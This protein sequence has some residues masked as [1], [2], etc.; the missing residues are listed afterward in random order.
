MSLFILEQDFKLSANQQTIGGIFNE[1]EPWFIADLRHFHQGDLLFVARDEARLNALYDSLSYLC[2]ESLILKFPA[3]DCLPYD[4]VS[5]RRDIVATRVATLAQLSQAQAQPHRLRVILTTPSALVQ[6]VPPKAA[7]NFGTLDLKVGDTIQLQS[8]IASLSEHGYL[9][10]S[11]V[12]EPGEFALRGGILDIFPANQEHPYRLDLFGDEIESIRVFDPLSQRSEQ[13]ATAVQLSATGEINLNPKTIERFRT[14]YRELFPENLKTDLLYQDI[15]EGRPHAGME[16]WL[17]LFYDRLETVLDYL[18]RPLLCF[19]HGTTEAL[20]HR[21]E[22]IQDHYQ[23]R[24]EGQALKLEG[25]LRYNPLP[26]HHL[27]LTLQDLQALPRV[28]C[29]PFKTEGGINVDAQPLSS[30]FLNQKQRIPALK[31]ALQQLGKGG[32]EVHVALGSR[33]Q[34]YQLIEQLQAQDFLKIQQV[35]SWHEAEQLPKKLVR[36]HTLDLNQGFQTQNVTFITEREIFGEKKKKVPK[37]SKRADLFIAEA[38]ALTLGDY[39]VHEDHGIGQFDGLHTL[40]VN[41]HPHDCLKVLYEGG[42]KLF[43][44]VENIDLISRYGGES[45]QAI[46]DRLGA[47][48]WQARK[49]KVKKR[50][51]EIANHLIEIAAARAVRMA[52]RFTFD[53]GLYAEF[54]DRF[55]FT[56][57]D[58]Q[59]R[60]IEDVI[61]DLSSGK[62][63]DRLV[64]GDVGFGKTEVALRAAFIVAQGGQQVAII[65]PTTLLA[66]QHY[67]NF[68]KRFQDIP[69]RVEQLSRLVTGKQASEIKTD[70]AA[71]KIDI[72]IGTH[73]LLA[74][75]V[76]FKNLG[77]VIVDEEQ[78]FG[79]KQKERL[80]ALQKDIHILT[81]TATPIPR[82]LQMA[83]TGVRDL[84]IIATPPIDRLAVRT[85]ITPFDPVT[86]KEA[87]T[88][89]LNRNGQL[90]YVCPRVKDLQDVLD[91]VGQIDPNLRIAVA[92]GQMPARQLEQV[93]D[94]FADHKYDLLLSTNIIESGID[95]P[96]VNTIFI[97]RADLFGLAQLYQLRGRI[98]RG[99]LR[100]YAY[101]T[102]PAGQVLAKNALR[103]LEVMQTLDT[104]GAG[105]QLASHDMDIRGAGNLLGEE[106]SGHVREV[107]VELYQQML[108]DAVAKA[109]QVP[110]DQDSTRAL[111]HWSPQLNLGVSV[112]I[113]EA[114]VSDL[115]IRLEL[116]RRLAA[117]EVEAEIEDLGQELVDRFG[118]YPEEV[119]NLLKIMQLKTL[120]RRAGIDKVDVGEKGVV[121]RFY[122]NQVQAPEKLLQY[123]QD[124]KGLAKLRPDHTIFFTRCWPSAAARFEG[125]GALLQEIT[126]LLGRC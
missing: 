104:L 3:W 72:I 126:N 122:Q 12:H 64:C 93:M 61:T 82:T 23:N 26:P 49:A 39:I 16:H 2:P 84:S 29:D 44:P 120:A 6:R 69:L 33:G 107:G 71:G 4:R 75:S 105:F 80:K 60:A 35:G 20:A 79:V 85:F 90:F 18:D 100:A 40:A 14:K 106:Q 96:T 45:S 67:A 73:A 83:L 32:H 19:S 17:P 63:M 58:D 28:R 92:H 98:G 41:G 109:R 117:L 36:V 81:L 38:S 21:F 115:A 7:M 48:A 102:Y 27:Y 52:K 10:V 125:C 13:A 87:I 86:V 30:T 62:P 118:P 108:E 91:K 123:I 65:A 101:L 74:E 31:A 5:P 9:R 55:A 66:R 112:L 119:K 88:R 68:Q 8:V 111:D 103:R 1:L 94:D 99:K 57:T 43:L 110:E 89:E 97:H 37:R 70:L 78:H 116:Y 95:L 22:V 46:V 34:A 59:H 124:Q 56:E 121:F 11:S 50:L 113:P 25:S 51:E 114:Y 54:T 53:P 15:S 24:L 42:D 76:G 47:A 77:L